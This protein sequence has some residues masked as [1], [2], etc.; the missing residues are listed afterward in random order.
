MPGD[1]QKIIHIFRPGERIQENLDDIR[2][3]M[4][5]RVVSLVE[6][7]TVRRDGNTVYVEG[8]A[9]GDSAAT[10]ERTINRANDKLQIK[11][12]RS[13]ASGTVP[14]M[15]TGGVEWRPLN[16]VDE[17]SIEERGGVTQVAKA[18]I[19]AD[20]TVFGKQDNEFGFFPASAG[21][22]DPSAHKYMQYT[23]KTATVDGDDADTYGFDWTRAHG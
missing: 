19:A 4:V 16:A 6:G 7:I 1:E 20:D 12:A 2:E 14:T 15:G 18:D 23:K 8:A 3:Q 5:A 17:R 10:D 22:S 11:G 21:L 9:G 13:A